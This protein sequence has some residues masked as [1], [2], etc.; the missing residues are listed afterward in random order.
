MVLQI[1]PQ[2]TILV[3]VE[4]A[5]FR[6]GIDGLARLCQEALQQ[7]PFT[8]VVFVFRNRN[9]TALKVLIYDGQGFWLCH[10]RLS[11]GRFRWWPSVA[12]G[13][14]SGW[15]PISCRCCSRPAT[16]RELLRARLASG[17]FA[18]LTGPRKKL[19]LPHSGDPW[20]IGGQMRSRA[21]PR[22]AAGE[23]FLPVVAGCEPRRKL[24]K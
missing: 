3:A 21:G 5:D 23:L 20:S 13:G 9:A 11:Q 18:D 8:G 12:E 2:M 4:P 17:G 10:K 14:A 15:P 6:K 1:T 7:D 22:E 24:S 19:L 16:R